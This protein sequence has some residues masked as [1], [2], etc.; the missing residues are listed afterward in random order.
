MTRVKGFAPWRPQK[1]TEALLEDVL[2]VL[3]EYREYLPLTVRQV[4]YR[5]AVTTG[6]A[7]ERGG[8]A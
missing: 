1:K 6:A 4:F 7:E 3:D 5:L 2:G 8:A